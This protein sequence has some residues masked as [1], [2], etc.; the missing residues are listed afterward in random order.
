MGVAVV[1]HPL[2]TLLCEMFSVL[3]IK[4]TLVDL[5]SFTFVAL[6]THKWGFGCTKLE[7]YFD[8]H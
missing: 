6:H 1:S 7:C 3:L 2:F 5:G 4:E 8:K